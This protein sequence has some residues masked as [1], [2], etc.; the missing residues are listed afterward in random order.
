M[1]F[2]PHHSNDGFQTYIW[3]DKDYWL[4]EFDGK[5]KHVVV[6]ETSTYPWQKEPSEDITYWMPFNYQS[7]FLTRFTFKMSRTVFP[8]KIKN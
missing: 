2:E 3:I 4:E 6:P 7:S 1:Y 8:F 5:S